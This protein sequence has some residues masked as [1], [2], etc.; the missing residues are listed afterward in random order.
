M[1]IRKIIIVVT[2][3][4]L[5][6]C[7]SIVTKTEFYYPVLTNLSNGNYGDAATQIK[8]AELEGEYADKDRVL[9]YLDK[10]IIFHYQGEYEKS[11]E[12]FDKA[13]W[14]M[15]ELFTKSISKGAA[16]LL[17]NDNALDY[18]GEVY[19]DLYINVFKSLNYIHLNNFD[20]AYVEIKKVND[21]L[22]LLDTKYEKY[23]SS[24][25][26]SESKKAE[27]KVED[28]E[29][30]NNVLA[31]YLS[32]LIFRT[33]GEYD[34]RRISLDKLYQ[35]WNT[36]K[37]VYNYKKPGFLRDSSTAPPATILN[38]IAFTGQ[39]PFKKAVGARITTFD[40]FVTV[41]DP[42]NYRV[43]AIPFPGIKY[44]W[45]FKFE[46]PELVE[47]GTEVYD[48]EVY[49]DSTYYGRLE[50]LENMANVA[51]KTFETQ[52]SITFFKTITRAV[53]KGIGAS[54]LGREITNNKDDL[55][56]NII[57]ALTN[58]AVDATENA[59]LRSWRTMPSY[60]FATQIPLE[61][62]SYRI[63]LRFIGED[64]SV[65][66][67]ELIENFRITNEMNLLESVYLK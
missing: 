66:K 60:C 59:D 39:A 4:V 48:I 56:S 44:G 25:E 29:Y 18:S 11:N 27:I 14:A 55:L 10:G 23:V 22:N 46:F 43:N 8:Q 38:I 20:A 24:L 42:T 37:D 17:L 62:G 30:Y 26:K 7:S 36:Y 47:E 35:A 50:L 41:S 19:E 53:L 33:E 28:L 63:E 65:I 40:D 6:A 32:A 49:I 61:K 51:R 16:S 3:L 21:K 64:G 52:K 45:N 34:N 5:S 1:K 12:E 2:G 13:E 57:V 9:L 67:S 58:A 54:S 31:N 15:E